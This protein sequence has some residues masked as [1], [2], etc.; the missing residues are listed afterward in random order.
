[1]YELEIAFYLNSEW[2]KKY[3]NC[4]LEPSKQ[5][6]P[7]HLSIYNDMTTKGKQS[8][9]W[10]ISCDQTKKMLLFTSAALT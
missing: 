2:V 8:K 5:K 6:K 3:A 1:M 10:Q 7:F 9:D 4:D